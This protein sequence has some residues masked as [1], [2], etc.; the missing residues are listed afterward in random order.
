MPIISGQQDIL[1]SIMIA[2]TWFKDLDALSTLMSARYSSCS[3][4][5][6]LGMALWLHL[7]KHVTFM[8]HLA[9]AFSGVVGGSV[10][11]T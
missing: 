10:V 6:I 3:C 4:W 1:S 9:G 7:L 2:I 11:L 8:V 5:F